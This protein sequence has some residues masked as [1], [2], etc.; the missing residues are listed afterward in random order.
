[1]A[2]RLL[3]AKPFPSANWLPEVP[4]GVNANEIGTL[5]Q[6]RLRNML[7]TT[8]STEMGHF[9]QDIYA[10]LSMRYITDKGSNVIARNGGELPGAID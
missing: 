10:S 2:C 7:S 8:S 6:G 5:I 4:V 1:M 9:V 3:D